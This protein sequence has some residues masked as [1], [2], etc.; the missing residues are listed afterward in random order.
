[1]LFIENYADF[2]VPEPLYIVQTVFWFDSANAIDST[3]IGN[4]PYA[5]DP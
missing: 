1:M 3:T 5:I 2:D 4:I